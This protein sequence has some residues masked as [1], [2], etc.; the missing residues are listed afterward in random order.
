[1][2]QGEASLGHFGHFDSLRRRIVQGP[3]RFERAARTR[4]ACNVRARP[5]MI[6]VTMV[7]GGGGARATRRRRR[8]SCQFLTSICG[9]KRRLHDACTDTAYF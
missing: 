5:R 1:M 8:R 4:A 9:A 7:V 6:Y 2:G 3:R